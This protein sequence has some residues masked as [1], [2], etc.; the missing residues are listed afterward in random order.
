MPF[1][2][3]ANNIPAILLTA[4]NYNSLTTNNYWHCS[5]E[6][7]KKIS[8]DRTQV[9]WNVLLLWPH[10]VRFMQLWCIYVDRCSSYLSLICIVECTPCMQQDGHVCRFYQQN[11]H[12]NRHN[13]SSLQ[14][15]KYPIMITDRL[16]SLK[17]KNKNNILISL[18][19]YLQI[20]C[21]R[22]LSFVLTANRFWWRSN[23]C[24][25]LQLAHL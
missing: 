2:I 20:T 5:T 6:Y 18:I 8:L 24:V 4:I 7:K 15:R 23:I 12:N 19:W 14:C 22:S 25:P 17:W 11:F 9:Y 1:I 10:C 3:L 21:I 16:E 13:F